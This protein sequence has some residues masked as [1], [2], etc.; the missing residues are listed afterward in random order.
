VDRVTYREAT[1]APASWLV[2]R[3]QDM[4]GKTASLRR[5]IQLAPGYQLQRDPSGS[6]P[7][8]VSPKG[9]IQLNESAAV[10]LDLCNGTFSGEEIVARVLRD[11]DTNLAD[12]VRAFLD[13]ARRRG[14]ILEG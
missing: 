8:L 6:G 9:P 1:R 13:A 12:D 3:S 10:I 2:R 5:T 4:N 14:W 7:T 11:K